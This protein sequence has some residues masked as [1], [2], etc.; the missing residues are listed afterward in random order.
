M[1]YLDD[2]STM[3]RMVEEFCSA[4]KKTCTY[5]SYGEFDGLRE[6]SLGELFALKGLLDV[7]I[8]ETKNKVQ[9]ESTD[10]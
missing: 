6:P 7:A 2:E 4:A 3:G 1:S 10:K 5:H 9:Q 8:W